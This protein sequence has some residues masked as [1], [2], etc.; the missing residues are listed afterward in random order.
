MLLPPPPDPELPPPPATA[1]PFGGT[2]WARF[3]TSTYSRQ[4]WLDAWNCCQW[5][6]AWEPMMQS[7]ICEAMVA[8]EIEEQKDCHGGADNASMRHATAGVAVGN[9]KRR[10]FI[11]RAA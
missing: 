8:L 3:S 2:A 9:G 7:G 10:D 6:I 1:A 5:S 11:P 4:K